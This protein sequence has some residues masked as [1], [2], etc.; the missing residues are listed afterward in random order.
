[1]RVD[2]RL[3]RSF[4]RAQSVLGAVGP[5][6]LAL[7]LSHCGSSMRPA[8]AQPDVLLVDVLVDV[9]DVEASLPDLPV[10]V[11]CLDSSMC[12]TACADLQNDPRHCGTCATNCTT[13]AGV[14]ADQARCVAG[15]CEVSTACL[16]G[17]AHCS[18][19]DARH[20]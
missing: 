14:I 13:L 7:V 18:A 16:P 5:C 9:L 11:G 2:L 19:N 4:L 6:L 3:D 17:R 8:V 12:G 1:M 10:D 15:R 20:A